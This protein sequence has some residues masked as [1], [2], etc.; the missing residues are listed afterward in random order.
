[1]MY[2]MRSRGEL[3]FLV[4]ITEFEGQCNALGR[5]F[6]FGEHTKKEDVRLECVARMHIQYEIGL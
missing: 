4:A 6:A 1:M 3:Y 2:P 5:S